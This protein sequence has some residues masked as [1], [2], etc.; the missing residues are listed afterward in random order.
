MTEYSI[1]FNKPAYLGTE[2]TYIAE[3]LKSGHLSGDGTFTRKC[4]AILE[5]V[6]GVQ[7]TLLTT[8]CTHALEMAAMLLEIGPGDEVIIPSSPLSQ[9][10]M[11]SFFTAQH[12]YLLMSDLTP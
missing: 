4:H 8:S 7:K 1:P 6:L 5:Q 12:L 3:V 2:E 9:R 10:S 11:R